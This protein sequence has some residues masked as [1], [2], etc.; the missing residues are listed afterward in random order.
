MAK[1]NVY[2]T[3][4]VPQPALDLLAGHCD[5]EINPED[6]VLTRAELLEKV[7]GRDGILCLLTDI[8]DDEVFTAAKGARIF[9]NLAVGFNNVDLEAATRHGIMIT[10]T[11]GVLTEAT[12]D[13]AWALLFAV[14]RR[15]VEGDKFTRAGKFKGWGPLLMLGQEITGKTLGVI[16]AGRIG[17]AF[18]RKARG[19]DMKVLYHDVQPSK[20]FEEATGGQFVDKE[21]LL[22]EADFVSL[23]VPL[24]PSTTHL[25]STPEL[26]LMKKT[27]ILINTS[28]GPVVDEKALV[29]ALREKEIW[30]AGLDVFEN[31]PELAPGL[32]D[33]ENVVLCPHI[34]SATW[35]TR[36]NMALMAANNLLAALRGELPPQ[37]LNPEVYYRQH[38]VR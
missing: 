12:A 25:I 5:L 17:T 14:A 2:V 35:E 37:C 6:R 26:K 24:M 19:F 20:A 34:A 31:E 10:N 22:K 38:G 1:W 32:A 16:G 36:T 9:A 7:R 28:R 27:A 13:M 8:L 11:P 30:G 21:T 29:K 33:L 15:V 3:R 4:P 18:A 23:H